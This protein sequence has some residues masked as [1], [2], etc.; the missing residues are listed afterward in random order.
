MQDF[1]ADGYTPCHNWRITSLSQTILAVSITASSSENLA[2]LP[3]VPFAN[4]FFPFSDTK[5]FR[6]FLFLLHLSAKKRSY[7]KLDYVVNLTQH[8]YTHTKTT[9]AK[10]SRNVHLECR[11]L[12][13]WPRLKKARSCLQMGCLCRMQDDSTYWKT[14]PDEEELSELL[15]KSGGLVSSVLKRYVQD[16]VDEEGLDVC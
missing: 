11:P 10:R 12:Q 16:R 5:I 14:S 3:P 15:W 6:A 8:Q 4:R 13:L 1:E 2:T 7:P 9:T